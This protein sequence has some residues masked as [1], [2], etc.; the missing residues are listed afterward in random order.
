MEL[1]KLKEYMA[2]RLSALTNIGVYNGNVPITA[3][4][5]YLVFKFPAANQV[6]RNR[7]DKIMEIDYWDDTNDDTAILAASELVKNG[8]YAIDGITLLVP[9]LDYS[10]QSEAE[11][12]YQCSLDFEGEIEDQE[13]NVSR[14]NQRYILKVR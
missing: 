9:G 7:S 4:F 5:P 13:S 6:V 1:G 2:I 11:G 12:F 3:T 10:R 8:K 14:I